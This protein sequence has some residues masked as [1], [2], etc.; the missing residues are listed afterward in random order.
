MSDAPKRNQD[1]VN[2]LTIV[3]IGICSAVLVYVSIAALQA[4][5]SNDVADVQTMADY[6]GQDQGA[7]DLRSKQVGNI[8]TVSKGATTDKGATFQIKIDD[9]M[10]KTLEAAKVDPADL[11]PMVGAQKTPTIL[12]VFGRP[13][14]IPAPATTPPPATDGS[15]SGSGSATEPAAPL[16]PTGTTAGSGAH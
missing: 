6:G 13:K 8:S 10:K 14:L 11:V 3:M 12:P 5:Y 4:F 7:K 2:S 16:V 9:A 1:K 15:G